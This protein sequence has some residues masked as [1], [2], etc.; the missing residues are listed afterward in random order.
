MSKK[1]LF[2]NLAVKDLPR[3]KAFFAELGF[4]FE[5]KFTDQN[6]ACMILAKDASYVMLLAEPFFRTFTKREICDTSKS[7][8]AFVC[9]M[10]ESRK[11]VDELCERALT[12]GGT[13]AM[14]PQ[15]HGFM[16]GR[17]FYDPDGH[18]WEVGWMDPNAAPP[19][20]N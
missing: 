10:V 16:Y 18:H 20:G 1:L 4:E 2:V 3:T 15:D 9:L 8:E 5:P 11:A 19:H 13:A 14:P 6:A 12:L 17:S 7:T